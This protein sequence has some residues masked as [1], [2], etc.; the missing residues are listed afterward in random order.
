MQ[1]LSL[2]PLPIQII[3]LGTIGYEEALE[4]QHEIHADV[5]KGMRP[6]TLILWEHQ[7]VIT[8]GKSAAT[9]S[10]LSEHETLTE[11]GIS[12]VKTGRGGDFTYHGPGQ[13]IAYPII[14]LRTRKRDV[15]WYMRGLEEVVLRTLSLY[16]VKGHRIEGRTGVF[17][18][19]SKNIH[20]ERKQKICSIGVRISRWCTLH[21]LALY[22]SDQ[23]RGFSH[24]HPCGY[25]DI[26][27]ASLEDFGINCDRKELEKNFLESFCDVFRFVQNE[28]AQGTRS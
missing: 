11:A 22:I 13:L 8:H 16:E 17:V 2:E 6:Q 9:E 21:G 20:P 1:L 19:L 14:D 5:Q 12:L 18:D 3:A 28:R 26:D 24:L 15:A 25:P 7:P 27:V 10:L 23:S 4:I